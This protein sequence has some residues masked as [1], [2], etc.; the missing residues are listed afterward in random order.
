MEDHEMDTDATELY[1]HASSATEQY[2]SPPSAS[3]IVIW[4]PLALARLARFDYDL[5]CLEWCMSQGLVFSR[6]DCGRHRA[7]RVIRQREDRRPSWYCGKC[8]DYKPIM[9]R[10]IFE[11]SQLSLQKVLMLAY[12]FARDCDYENA[13]A[14]CIFDLADTHLSSN[15][16]N[17]WYSIFR[18]KV[19]SEVTELIEGS[20]IGGTGKI[21]QVDEALIGR[22]KYNRGRNV[23]GT[24]VVGLIDEDGEVRMEI[25]ERRD[26][27]TLTALII[28][29]VESG[30]II[31]TDSWRGYSTDLLAWAGLRH[32]TVNHREE[33]VTA[34]GVHTQRIESQWRILRRKFT[35]GGK[36]NEDIA[37]TL[38]EFSW[39]RKCKNDNVDTFPEL[40]KLLR[41]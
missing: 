13:R 37:E 18:D 23:Q 26:Q 8:N 7:P 21:V 1:S 3:R 32:E 34:E 33:F 29:H 17:H 35:P 27:E 24:W 4:G 20:K 31:H 40:L 6:M 2:L 25:V 41:A 5:A 39:R 12:C 11:D 10:S 38:L 16:I 14:N 15:T 9:T 28:R 19:T 30:S 36:R 22:R